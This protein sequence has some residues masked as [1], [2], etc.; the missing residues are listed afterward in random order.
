MSSPTIKNVV[1]GS[2]MSWNLDAKPFFPKG[3]KE[4]FEKLKL[5]ED[6]YFDHLENVWFEQN[7][8]MFED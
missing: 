2:T 1:I 7:K 8:E 5:E 6:K 3:E 4:R